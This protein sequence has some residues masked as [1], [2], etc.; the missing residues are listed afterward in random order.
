MAAAERTFSDVKEV[1]LSAHKDTVAEDKVG[2][3][4]KWANNYEQDVDI[5]D[6]RAPYLAAECLSAAFQ[7]DRARAVVLDVA[8][9]TG[10][11]ASLL[12]KKG[13]QNFHGV[14]GSEGML[15]LAH[16]KGLYQDLKQCILGALP[17]PAPAESYDAVLIVGALSVGQVPCSVIRELWQ[18]TKPGGY[19]CMTTRANASNR[20]YKEKLESVLQLMEQ[21]GLWSRVTVL[22]E[23]LWEKAVS[24]QESGYI[25]GVVYLYRKSVGARHEQFNAMNQEV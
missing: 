5:L 17:L 20:E 14:D 7:G 2:F 19:V 9:D 6:Y 16:R 11:V 15:R 10:L 25:P 3:Y 24:D 12:Q 23:D 4:N 18:A 8:C 13:F 1:I 22:E 21:K